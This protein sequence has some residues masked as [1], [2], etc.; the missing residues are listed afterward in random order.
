[1]TIRASLFDLD[2]TLYPAS[3]GFQHLLDMR[4]MVY[5]SELLGVP[6]DEARTIRRGY[7]ST[8]GTTLRG[9]Q[10]HHQVDTEEFLAYVHD[11]PFD[12]YLQPDAELGVLLGQLQGEKAIFTNSPI[13]HTNKVLS[14]LGIADHFNHIF[15]IRFQEFNPKPDIVGYQQALAI[16]GVQG[17]E[18][19]MIE[20]T[21]KNLATARHLGMMTIYIA[22]A[23]PDDNEHP[24]DSVVSDIY[25]A[26]QA[27][28]E[29]QRV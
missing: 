3:L 16:L 17:S 19:V 6:I 10:I 23:P 20:D 27:V 8:Y 9:L 15:D 26:I 22:D 2:S 21:L 1:M 4:I 7:F 24:A 11:L 25:Q 12:E 18:A 29:R 13:E 14:H 28:I 5:M